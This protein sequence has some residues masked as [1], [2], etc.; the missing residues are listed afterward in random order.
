MTGA[1]VVATDG[2]SGALC[3][4]GSKEP[5]RVSANKVENPYVIGAGDSTL[6]GLACALADGVPLRCAVEFAMKAGE[7]S[8][9]EFGTVIVDRLKF[10][11]S[12]TSRDG[13][14]S[15]P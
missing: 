12:V 13:S 1:S 4:D 3:L 7:A 9:K 2:E 11:D 14:Y 10:K 5:Y 8:V 15:Q 6:A